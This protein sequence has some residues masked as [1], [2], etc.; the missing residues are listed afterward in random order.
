MTRA[1]VWKRTSTSSAG[2]QEYT[3]CNIQVKVTNPL[4]WADFPDFSTWYWAE[5][6][7]GNYYYSAAE[8]SSANECSIQAADYR[9]GFFTTTQDL[10]LS[11][12]VSEEAE[13]IKLHY[14]RSGRDIV[15]YIDLTGGEPQ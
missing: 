10:W 2:S 15:L 5:D 14:A 11:P 12:C 9:T 3:H 13:W 8:D 7:L 4:P 6:S 1:S